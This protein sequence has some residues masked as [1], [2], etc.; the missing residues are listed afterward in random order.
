MNSDVVTAWWKEQPDN[1]DALLMWARVQT[2][3]ALN[4]RCGA[5]TARVVLRSI[6]D[7]RRARWNAAQTLPN[8][9][10]Q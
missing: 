2:Q 10:V 1:A 9:P 4:A 3:R 7:A 6:G 8:D 5:V